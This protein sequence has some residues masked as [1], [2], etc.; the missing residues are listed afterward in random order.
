VPKV[1]DADRL[2]GMDCRP[3]RWRHTGGAGIGPAIAREL[4]S[5]H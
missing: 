3:S 5:A 4:V 2:T 1:V